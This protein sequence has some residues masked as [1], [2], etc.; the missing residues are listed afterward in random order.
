MPMVGIFL[1]MVLEELHDLGMAAAGVVAAYGHDGIVL[2]LEV[3]C[4]L[5]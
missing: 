5:R 1:G 2:L 3:Y 4:A